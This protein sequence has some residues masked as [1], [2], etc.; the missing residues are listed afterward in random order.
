LI[1]F[2]ES[3]IGLEEQKWKVAQGRYIRAVCI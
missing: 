2:R 3:K 1:A